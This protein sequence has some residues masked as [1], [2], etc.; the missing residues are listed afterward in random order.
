MSCAIRRIGA[1][2]AAL[3]LM[4]W[5]LAACTASA[6]EKT[7]A[8]TYVAVNTASAGLVAF[9]ARHQDDLVVGAPDEAS[10]KTALAEYRAKRELAVKAIDAA[11]RAIATAAVLEDDQSL[12]A[13][14]A[15]ALIVKQELQELGVKV[16]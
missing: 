1:P 16:P 4:A 14:L 9:D 6:R 12:A 5:I 15:A 3:L 8:G 2:I 7:I 13:M 11:F 10:G